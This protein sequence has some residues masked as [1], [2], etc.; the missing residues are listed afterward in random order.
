MRVAKG[1]DAIARP[2]LNRVIRIAARPGVVRAT[3]EDDFHHFRVTLRHENGL[4]TGI[5]AESPRFPYSLCPV[6]GLRL[7]DV[8]GMELTADMTAVFRVADARDQCTHQI[9]LAALAVTAAARGTNRRRYEIVV[10]DRREGEPRHALL[11]RDGVAMLDWT[12]DGYAIAAPEPFAGRGLGGG[13]TSWVAQALVAEDAEAALVLR[14]G[15]FISGGRGMAERLDAMASA[16][17]TGGCW[18]Q[19][20]DRAPFA[21]RQKGSTQD[22]TGRAELLT[23]EDDAWLLTET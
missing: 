4:V 8:I 9:D 3:L 2:A 10:E 23:R 5:E 13:F 14:R 18:V 20:S 22:F 1:M 12:L 19:Q 16:P 15:V 21:T 6:A 17:T 7:R 11:W